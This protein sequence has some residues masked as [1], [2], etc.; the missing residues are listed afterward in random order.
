[1][2]LR[3][4]EHILKRAIQSLQQLQNVKRCA[5]ILVVLFTLC[6]APV[7]AG[8]A[9]PA[10]TTA[11]SAGCEYGYPPFSIVEKSG[12]ANGFSVELLRAALRTMDRDVAFRVGSWAEI[13]GLLNKGEIDAL[14]LVARTPEREAIFE[15]TFPYLSLH[16]VIV[17]P[18]DTIDIHDI[19]DLEGRR[20]A[21][22]AGDY[23]EEFLRRV[24][25]GL[26][27]HTTVTFEEAL[28]E[29]SDGRHDAVVIQRL[30]ALRFI[31]Q[32]GISNGA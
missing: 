1:M 10:Q 32:A 18:K 23:A 17:V 8:E 22:I 2:I 3:N 14:P 26:E 25:L 21:V 20:V 5:P 19:N 31:Q 24:D 27:I 15:F 7:F 30:V 4:R 9:D 28:S 29:L 6:V 16:G 13:K 12:R 11:I